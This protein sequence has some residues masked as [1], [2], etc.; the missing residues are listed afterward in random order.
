LP[1]R[2]VDACRV[3]GVATTA[4]VFEALIKICADH[5]GVSVEGACGISTISASS[6]ASRNDA[7]VTTRS[8]APVPIAREFKI[9]GV[10]PIFI[11]TAITGLVEF[12]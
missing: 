7:I 4:I 5:P 11:C 2:D 3:L 9:Q 1:I 6:V 8:S 10:D 12:I